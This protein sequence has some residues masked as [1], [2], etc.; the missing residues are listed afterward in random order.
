MIFDCSGNPP[1]DFILPPPPLPL[2][3][4]GRRGWRE[5][6]L[7]RKRRPAVPRAL[8]RS[9]VLAKERI[10]KEGGRE[11]GEEGRK[12]G[13]SSAA[14]AYSGL[15]RRRRRGADGLALGGRK[16]RASAKAGGCAASSRGR[17]GEEGKGRV[18]EELGERK[19]MQRR[20]SKGVTNERR[21][22]I[23]T[24]KSMFKL[25]SLVINLL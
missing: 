1:C 23:D 20:V 2:A 8:C 4:L 10:E 13:C 9:E 3:R 25:S 21:S 14:A 18:G 6:G 17:V 16:G 11:G 19:K 15:P 7:D 5:R 22:G 24:P 12:W